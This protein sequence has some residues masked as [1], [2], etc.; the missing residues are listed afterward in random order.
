MSLGGICI[1]N[2]F[3]SSC[4][5][6]QP[7]LWYS[8][9]GNEKSCLNCLRLPF[10]ICCIS[11]RDKVSLVSAVGI[12]CPWKQPFSRKLVY[13]RHARNLTSTFQVRKVYEGI[14]NQ[15]SEYLF[16]LFH[17]YKGIT[18]TSVAISLQKSGAC[19]NGGLIWQREVTLQRE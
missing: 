3:A 12:K 1:Q 4:C 17:G 2:C 15:S 16:T 8:R 10:V 14:S 13:A 9:E 7:G 18:Y 5:F 6:P 11:C 19:M